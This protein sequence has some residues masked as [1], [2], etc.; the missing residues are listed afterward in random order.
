[1][2][3]VPAAIPAASGEAQAPCRVG[4]GPVPARL[5]AVVVARCL[6]LALLLALTG[7]AGLRDDYPR[8]TSFAVVDYQQ[9]G[10]ARLFEAA[11]AAH[12]DQ[13]GFALIRRGRQAFNARIAL[14]DLAEKSLDLQYFIWEDDAT[15][16][17]L[18]ERL[19]RAADR[20]VRVRVLV[21]DVLL[22]G[23]DST[24]AALDA[25]PNIDIRIFNPFTDRDF[26]VLD[27]VVDMSRVNH[28][29]H[30]KTMIV[31]NAVAIVG[32]RNVGDI[33]F[34]VA[35]EANYRD[36]DV[37]AAGPIV[38]EISSVFDHFWN[39]EWSVPIGALVDRSP[40]PE[41]LRAA[42]DRLRQRIAGEEY[43]YPLERD[44]G[45]LQGELIAVRDQFAWAPGEIVWN[46]PAGMHDGA[47]GG[48]IFRR[49]YEEIAT[50]EK[51][52]LIESAYFV[53]RQ[54]GLD[55]AK[56]LHDRGVRVRILTNSLASNDVLTAHAGYAK[57]RKEL[58]ASGVELH[59]MRADAGT[60]RKRLFFSRSRA[61]LHAKAVIFDRRAVFI[62]S[63]NLDPRSADIN[64]E[65]GLYI[66]SPEL[67]SQL[68]E[69]MDEATRPENSYRVML[70]AQGSLIWLA[71]VDGKQ[72][73]YHSDPESSPQRRF[74]AGLIGLLP[75]Q[76]QL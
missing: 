36:L 57:F 72:V 42:T 43:P 27:Y 76:D 9:T 17:I 1:M 20:G 66:E 41:D 63:Y 2:R 34:Q 52:L 53:L 3:S 25:H 68:A 46:D 10:L 12:P 24:I 50:L 61:A 11:A 65:A 73:Q 35:T 60:I 14:T 67:A 45:D 31:D 56:A 59:E 37:V 6:A 44:V 26:H 15:G 40:G 28:R 29:M 49:L 69:Y 54:R 23:R 19:V 38:R 8:P 33:Y 18:A 39:G 55:E 64:T 13:S 62:G 48:A 75:I 16:H 21:D 7:C 30:N 32:G 47:G 4:A 5:L 58:V 74:L 70:D 22:S 71:E 51:E